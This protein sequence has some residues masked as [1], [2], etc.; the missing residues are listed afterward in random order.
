MVD[1][2]YR[3]LHNHTYFFFF[4]ILEHVFFYFSIIIIISTKGEEE[5]IKKYCPIYIIVY[6]QYQSWL[7][8][9]SHFGWSECDN[10]LR[11]S[12]LPLH[13]HRLINDLLVIYFPIYFRW[14]YKRC[15]RL[16]QNRTVRNL[17]LSF[18][19]FCS[20]FF[21]LV[22]FICWLNGVLFVSCCCYIYFLVLFSALI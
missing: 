21:F 11:F 19:I 20:F 6:S 12:L 15:Y 2:S 3:Q 4:Y 7:F 9:F 16:R 1:I 8:M 14:A 10:S 17:L 13:I 18:F 5:G 22:L